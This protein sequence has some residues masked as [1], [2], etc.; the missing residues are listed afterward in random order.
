MTGAL[1]PAPET[2]FW[3]PESFSG[4]ELERVQGAAQPLAPQLLSDH[5]LSLCVRGPATAR[6]QSVAH[7]L[8]DTAFGSYAAGGT[9]SAAPLLGG[10][11]SYQT[12]RL[13]PELMA[14]L[15]DAAGQALTPTAPIPV[16]SAANRQL[17]GLFREAFSSFEENAPS[18]VQ[19]EKLVTLTRT[20]LNYQAQS[21]SLVRVT[22]RAEAAVEKVRAYLDETLHSPVS[23]EQVADH[24]QMSKFH[25]SKLFK[26]VVGLSPHAYG[27]SLRVHEAKRALK[28]LEPLAHIAFD[29]GFSDQAHFTRTFKRY[30]GMTPGQYQAGSVTA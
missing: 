29:L 9:F 19:E 8:Q 16:S 4:L 5:C 3:H 26:H 17:G 22:P 18:S 2:T 12:L 21:A 24:A 15:A 30:V 14:N 27:M 6:Y 23:L 28:R 13:S 25:L 7:T 1:N 10:S 20:L 11:W